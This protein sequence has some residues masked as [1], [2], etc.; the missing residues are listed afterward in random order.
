MWLEVKN[1]ELLQKYIDIYIETGNEDIWN[2]LKDVR[3]FPADTF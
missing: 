2:I 3:K 1:K